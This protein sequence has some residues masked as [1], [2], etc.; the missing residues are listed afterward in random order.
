MQLLKNFGSEAPIHLGDEQSIIEHFS[1]KILLKKP[2]AVESHAIQ[3]FVKNH[4]SD[5]GSFSLREPE[6]GWVDLATALLN[7]NKF[8]YID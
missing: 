6:A 5:D 2:L 8:A 4:T 3:A 1:R 7:S